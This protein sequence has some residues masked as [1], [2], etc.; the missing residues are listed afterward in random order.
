MGRSAYHPIPHPE[1]GE[2]GHGRSVWRQDGFQLSDSLVG[3]LHRFNAKFR[4]DSSGC[5]LWHGDFNIAGYGRVYFAGTRNVLAHR[6]S[7]ALFLGLPPGGWALHKCDVR[8][9]VNP[10]H[11][12]VGD[13]RDN[14]I[15]AVKKGRFGNQNTGKLVCIRGHPLVGDNVFWTTRGHRQCKAC[16]PVHKRVAREKRRS[17]RAS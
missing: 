2:W 3:L 15:D 14:A 5:W 17:E 10:D 11:L 6:L 12:F 13:R 16:R 9:C 1:T 8:N 4:V 7:V